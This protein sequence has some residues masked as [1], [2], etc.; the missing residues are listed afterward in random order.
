MHIPPHPGEVLKEYLDDRAVTETTAKL[1]V[2]SSP[3]RDDATQSTAHHEAGHVTLTLASRHFELADPAVI[4]KATKDRTAQAG[5]RPLDKS[6]TREK[7]LEHLKIALGGK[8]GEERFS[9]RTEALG[10]RI[11]LHVESTA[12]DL[13]WVQ[14]GLAYWKAEGDFDSLMASAREILEAH[15]DVWKDVADFLIA[16]DGKDSVG[17]A[18]IESLLSVKAMI[19]AKRAVSK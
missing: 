10:R 15:D 14:S 11:A 18:D 1:G 4:L 3:S 6:I 19:A 16:S 5:V 9:D 13:A 7:S 2:T 8:A 17:K 12:F